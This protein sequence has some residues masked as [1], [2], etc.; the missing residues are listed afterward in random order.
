M[1]ILGLDPGIARTGFGI[2]DSSKPQL[3]VNCG[4][5]TTS[6]EEEPAARLLQIG[7]DTITL[8]RKYK[9][10]TAVV[11]DIFF[12]TNTSTAILT[13]QTRGVLLYVLQEHHVRITSLTPLQIKSRLTGFG[14]ADKKQVQSMISRRLNLAC[15]PQPDDAADA[16]AAALC[17][18]DKKPETND[19]LA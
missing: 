10:D 3:Y 17:E 16:L 15:A 8:I 18:V 6:K 11:E 19:I 1:I 13:A 12:N 7:Q 14:R 2:L 4:C 5:L 9:P